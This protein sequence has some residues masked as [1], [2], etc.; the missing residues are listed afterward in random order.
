MTYSRVQ[1]ADLWKFIHKYFFLV[2]SAKGCSRRAISRSA[3]KFCRLVTQMIDVLALTNCVRI[4]IYYEINVMKAFWKNET[5]PFDAVRESKKF[6][7]L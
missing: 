2:S 6:I 5:Q 1:K 3:Y 4:V 7:I